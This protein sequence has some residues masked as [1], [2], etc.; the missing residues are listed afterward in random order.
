MIGYI[1]IYWSERVVIRLTVYIFI[2]PHLHAKRRKLDDENEPP[3][4]VDAHIRA[5]LELIC[6]NTKKNDSSGSAGEVLATVVGRRLRKRNVPRRDAST[7]TEEEEDVP[8]DPAPDRPQSSLSPTSLLTENAAAFY[9]PTGFFAPSNTDLQYYTAGAS[10]QPCPTE[11]R[12]HLSNWQQDFRKW[13]RQRFGVDVDSV[14]ADSTPQST[15]KSD[16]DAERTIASQ[17]PFNV[18]SNRVICAPPVVYAAPSMLTPLSSLISARNAAQNLIAY[19]IAQQQQQHLVAVAASLAALPTPI[20]CF[21][22]AEPSSVSPTS[23]PA[24]NEMAVDRNPATSTG[25]CGPITQYGVYAILRSCLLVATEMQG[26]SSKDEVVNCEL[27]LPTYATPEDYQTR[28]KTWMPPPP[29]S[30][31]L[32]RKQTLICIV[33]APIRNKMHEIEVRNRTSSKTSVNIDYV[34][35][36]ETVVEKNAKV[37]VTYVFNRIDRLPDD[38]QTPF[39]RGFVG[40]EDGVAIAS[41]ENQPTTKAPSVDLDATPTAVCNAADEDSVVPNSPTT[42]SFLDVD[43]ITFDDDV[44][45]KVDSLCEGRSKAMYICDLLIDDILICQ[46]LADCK[47]QAKS[48]ACRKALKLLSK[49]VYVVGGIRTWYGNG[50]VG[51]SPIDYLTLC[52]SPKAD[53]VPRLTPFLADPLAPIPSEQSICPE[54]PAETLKVCTPKPIYD[55]WL[56]TARPIAVN[57]D[58][59]LTPEQYLAQSAE[60]SQ[61]VVNFEVEFDSATGEFTTFGL[62]DAQRVVKSTGSNVISTRANAASHLLR[63]LK[64]SQPVVGL[65]LPPLIVAVDEELD[66]PKLTGDDSMNPLWGLTEASIV[67]SLMWGKQEKQLALPIEHLEA[68]CEID[69][70]SYAGRSDDAFTSA[71]S[72]FFTSR[73]HL[74]QYLEAYAASALVAPLRISLQTLPH[75]LWHLAR[76]TAHSWGLLTRIEFEVSDHLDTAFLLVCKRAPLPRLKRTLFEYTEVGVFYLLSKGNLPAEAL[77]AISEADLLDITPEQPIP[78]TDPLS[79]TSPQEEVVIPDP[80]ENDPLTRMART[81]HATSSVVKIEAADAPSSICE[82]DPDLL[83]VTAELNQPSNAVEILDDL[84]RQLI[85]GIDF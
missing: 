21:P 1:V 27:K 46:A 60:F 70:S 48:C 45:V 22:S 42:D 58:E 16:H 54:D 40:N 14:P 38:A 31:Q 69:S 44:D 19:V 77:R 85:P 8:D 51:E 52:I 6:K 53:G 28:L 36:L 20:V 4:Q 41:P 23:P 59:V 30:V 18:A 10:A 68:H 13:F 64:M 3:K 71:G 66:G 33:M 39:I 73:G 26:N 7:Q 63:Y 80:D 61:M 25:L 11:L 62:V 2:D 81:F 12:Q 84:P 9:A 24:N 55:L 50:A 35:A 37:K 47:L 74:D 43:E 82:E 5:F 83:L 65:L 78:F 17:T 56:Y 72:T 49:Y 15:L 29:P 57:V 34:A 76:A 75:S 79:P 32:L 67:D